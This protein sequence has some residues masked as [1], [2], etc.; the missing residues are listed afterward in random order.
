MRPKFKPSL[1]ETKRQ[2]QQALDYYKAIS[3][4]ED[5][6]RIDVGAKPKTTR[7]APDPADNEA[8]VLRSVSQI[9]AR[10]PNVAIAIRLN[11]GMAFNGSG[12]PVWFHKLIKGRGVCV[13]FVGALKDGR[14]LAIECKRP[15]WMP[16]K[17]SGDTAIRETEQGR[18]I[19]GVRDMGGVGGFVR[20]VDEAI[21]ILR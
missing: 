7:A 5:A 19:E 15:S 3:A 16:G 2:S 12:Q 11:S 20:G 18:Y 4:R 9:L 17:S 8:E 10:H 14:P 1:A 6:V 21:E 13:D